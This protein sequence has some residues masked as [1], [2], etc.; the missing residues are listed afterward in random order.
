MRISL[1]KLKDDIF[2]VIKL[3]FQKKIEENLEY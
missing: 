1:L 3:N 2:N